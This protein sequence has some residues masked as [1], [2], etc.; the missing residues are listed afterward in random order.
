MWECATITLQWCTG[1]SWPYIFPGS[2]FGTLNLRFELFGGSRRSLVKADL[3][4]RGLREV[5]MASLWAPLDPLGFPLGP[6]G[7]IFGAKLWRLRFITA[8][9]LKLSSFL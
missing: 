6:F 5:P 4:C 1:E 3:G 9:G 8:F 7:T 2:L